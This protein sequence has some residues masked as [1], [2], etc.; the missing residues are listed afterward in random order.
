MNDLEQLHNI[1]IEAQSM[2]K[3]RY[4]ARARMKITEALMKIRNMRKNN[5]PKKMLEL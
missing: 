5:E 4:P 2:L 3:S 1:L